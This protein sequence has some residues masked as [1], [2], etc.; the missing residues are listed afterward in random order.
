MTR[1]VFLLGLCLLVG[2]RKSEERVVVYCAQDKD[3]AEGIFADYKEQHR[4]N[5]E[6]KFDTEANKSVS[7]ALELEQEATRPRC[8]VHWNNE[9]LATIRLARKGLYEPYESPS[10]QPFPAWTKAKDNT[11]QAFASRA[12]VLIVNTNLVPEGERPTSV[13][14]LANPK[15]KGKAAMAKPLFGTTAT[16][17]ACLFAALGPDVAKQFFHDVKA[18]D[19]QL[20]AGNKQVA[21]QVSAGRYAFG[22]TD[23][24]D[25][26]IEINAGQPVT[27]IFPDRHGHPKHPALGVLF[28]PNTLAIIKGCPNPQNAR[29]LVDALLKPET[30]IRLGEGGGFQI[31]LNPNVKAK[32]PPQLLTPNEVQTMTVD[33]ESAADYW[34]EAQTFLRNEF[35][36]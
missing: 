17:A 18:N 34:E 31:P 25:A 3:F 28:I 19:V 29:K 8:D 27:M 24:D 23:T 15:W 7:L 14:D 26:L 21:T 35:A 11:W 6:P 1:T 33:F 12:R 36:R 32:L 13:L 22:L 30:E 2:C 10:A 5:I 4:L 20:L 16:H 9:I